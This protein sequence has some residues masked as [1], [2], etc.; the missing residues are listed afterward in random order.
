MSVSKRK[1]FKVRFR[2]RLGLCSQ[3][4]RYI[5]LA[6]FFSLQNASFSQEFRSTRPNCFILQSFQAGS[7]TDIDNL[8]ITDLDLGQV[9]YSNT[10]STSSSATDNLNLFYWPQGGQS[11]TN[12]VMNVPGKTYELQKSTD[13]HNWVV[14]QEAQ[15]EAY[16][17]TETTIRTFSSDEKSFYRILLKNN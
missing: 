12:F 5:S 9:V 13:L 4:L 10:F 7:T 3:L 14:V 11:T 8:I 16:P 15:S 17:A 1:E 6:F 2:R